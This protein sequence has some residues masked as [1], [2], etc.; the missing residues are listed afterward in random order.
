MNTYNTCIP[1]I[2]FGK[3]V[4]VPAGSYFFTCD[5]PDLKD[6]FAPIKKIRHLDL[7]WHD[8][9]LKELL[10]RLRFKWCTAHG[11]YRNTSLSMRQQNTLQCERWECLV[12]SQ[13][14]L[15]NRM[16]NFADPERSDDNISKWKLCRCSIKQRRRSERGLALKYTGK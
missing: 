11:S 9:L 16:Y 12:E 2:F 3:G 14:D 5:R 15:F 8:G 1:S 10:G 7:F 13:T 6:T 4:S